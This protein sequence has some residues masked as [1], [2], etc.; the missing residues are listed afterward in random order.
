[1]ALV[2]SFVHKGGIVLRFEG[3]DSIPLAD[4]LRGMVVA[5]PR[6]QRVLLP[7]D[8]VYVGDLIGCSLVDVASKPAQEIGVIED[9]DRDAGPVALLVVKSSQPIEEILVPFAKAYLH[10]IDLEAKCVEMA[11]PEGLVEAQTN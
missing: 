9:V 1:M 10:K 5:I 2:D 7:E 8:E 11:L 3:I 6:S 4:G